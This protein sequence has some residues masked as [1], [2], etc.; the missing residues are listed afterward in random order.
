LAD[1]L[2]SW[3]VLSH[4]GHFLVAFSLE[5]VPRCYQITFG[6]FPALSCTFL[7]LPSG[8]PIALK[9]IFEWLSAKTWEFLSIFYEALLFFLYL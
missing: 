1:S 4:P 3:I 9:S 8:C 5:K 6:H 7:A 2:I